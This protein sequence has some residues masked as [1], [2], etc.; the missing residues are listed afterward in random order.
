MNQKELEEKVVTTAGAK[1][2]LNAVESFELDDSECRQLLKFM[3]NHK[4][5][6]DHPTPPAQ[7]RVELKEDPH[8]MMY[9]LDRSRLPFGGTSDDAIAN[10]VFM[11]GDGTIKGISSIA[12]LTAFKE[13]LRWTS[14]A[15]TQVLKLL[16]VA[17]TRLAKYENVDVTVPYEGDLDRFLETEYSRY[18]RAVKGK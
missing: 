2:V 14:R 13:R 9:S 8:G 1:E 10:G 4:A 17:R 7:W 15:L 12:M 16:L 18:V 5:F 11:A 6:N 3:L